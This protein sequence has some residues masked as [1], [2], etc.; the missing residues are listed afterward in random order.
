MG[1][2]EFVT[3]IR[4]AKGLNKKLFAKAMDVNPVTVSNWERDKWEPDFE[5]L[6]RMVKLLDERLTLNQC[7]VLPS[8]SPES[9]RKYRA[10]LEV[11]GGLS[12]AMP[13]GL[14]DNQKLSKKVQKPGH[15]V[16][17]R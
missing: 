8:E 17:H 9:E 7:L 2:G 10:I 1:F 14:Q 3:R 13:A 12:P 6:D 15:V 5:K 11:I 4:T 16:G